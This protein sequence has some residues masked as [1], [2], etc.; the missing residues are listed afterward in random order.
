MKTVLIIIGASKSGSTLLAKTL[1]GHSKCFTL[2]EINRYNAEIKNP[3]GCCSC[4]SPLTQCTF[5]NKIQSKLDRSMLNSKFNDF[6]VGIFKQITSKTEIH[7]LIPTILFKKQ[8]N[9]KLVN[10][11][12]SN[13]L[14]LY[15]LI[16]KETGSEV[17]IDST[18]GLFR[19]LI[20]DSNRSKEVNF[21][22]VHLVRDGRGVLNSSLKKTYFIHH[23]DGTIKEYDK[24]NL[25]QPIYIKTPLEAINYWLYVNIRNFLILKL[26]RSGKTAFV[27]YERFTEDPERELRPILNQ[28]NLNYEDNILELEKNESHILGGNSSRINAKKIK[29]QDDAWRMNLPEDLL[30][31]FNN[32]AGWFNK[33]LGYQ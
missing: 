14:A 26:F 31:K 25:E 8:Y 28:L 7:K 33:I 2:G 23:E 21:Q 11:E 4:G 24:E 13:T 30:R 16:F 20:L 3:D 12:I 32:R 6:N 17:L 15:N 18:K 19:A 5:W 22:F 10:K 1:G 9:N 27:K 29:K